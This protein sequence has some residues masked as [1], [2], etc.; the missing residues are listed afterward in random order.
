[1]AFNSQVALTKH[2]R[3]YSQATD[4]KMWGYPFFST[5]DLWMDQSIDLSSATK[6]VYNKRL[7]QAEIQLSNHLINLY[8]LAG[9]MK[10]WI[11]WW[12]NS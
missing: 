6:P 11:F 8:K 2:Q 10:I 4:T 5:S 3:D 1:M 9:A 7:F 12:A